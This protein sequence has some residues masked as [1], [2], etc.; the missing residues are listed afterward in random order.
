RFMKAL[1]KTGAAADG[2]EPISAV[3]LQYEATLDLNSAAAELGL[4]PAEFVKRL[5]GSLA[6][7]RL[8]GP[9]KVKGGTVQRQLFVDAFP[10]LVTTFNLGAGPA[11]TAVVFSPFAGHEG[12][13]RCVALSADGRFALSGGED[14]TVR[15]WDVAT[16]KE[17]RRFHG[18]KAEVTA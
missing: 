13:V 11:E 12:A 14:R 5:S 17:L 16:G 9:L 10:E 7:S 3:T 6:L 2:P 15:L 1:A 18:H 8:L 4:A